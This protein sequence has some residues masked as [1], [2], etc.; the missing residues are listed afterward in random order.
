VVLRRHGPL[1]QVAQIG[2]VL[3]TGLR[4]FS[5]LLAR[6]N[7]SQVVFVERRGGTTVVRVESTEVPPHIAAALESLL[8]S[9]LE[10]LPRAA[11][12]AS[13]AN[14]SA[15][16]A[17]NASAASSAVG[18]HAP[19]RR[20]LLFRELVLAV[21]ERVRS[22]WDKA[23][24][25]HEAFS[26]SIELALTYDYDSAS[27]HDWPPTRS[28][29]EDTCSE[30]HELLSLSIDV[31][32]GIFDGW[33]TLTHRRNDLQARPVDTLAEAWPVLRREDERA[34]GAGGPPADVLELRASSAD[35]FVTQTCTAG[36]AAGFR[37]AGVEPR[38]VYDLFYSVASAANASF[39]C[40][41]HAVQTCSG[42][43]RR[44]WHAVVIVVLWFSAACV[45]FN[46]L[47]ISFLSSLLVPFFSLVVLQLCYG[48]TWTCAPMVPVCAWQD[49]SES[50]GALMPLSLEVPAELKRLDA[51]CLV[52]DTACAAAQ[53]S[54]DAC[55]APRRYPHPRC[56]KSC[57]E[58]PFSFT[59]WQHVVAWAVAEAGP[60]AVDWASTHAPRI[61]LFEHKAF[62]KN[63]QKHVN[64]LRRTSEDSVGAHRVCALLSSYM[65]LPY[66]FIVL[67][68]LAFVASLAQ[69]L[70]T[71]LLPVFLLVCTL[72]NAVADE[73]EGEAMSEVI[74]LSARH[75]EYTCGVCNV[76]L[77]PRSYAAL[78]GNSDTITCCP[79]CRRILFLDL[80]AKAE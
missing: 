21:E 63:I 47:G 31:A 80:A 45:I 17:A 40:P 75:R 14:A 51:H 18:A 13:A 77:P 19:G 58:A 29:G 9:V 28:A 71:Q 66:I 20:L 2:T 24:G 46:A 36:A 23:D 67:L 57:R 11:V 52:T 41:Y 6:R 74:E 60:W 53:S 61:P 22:G 37:A 8:E 12:N 48:Y 65:L 70:A 39:S 76:E 62:L 30:A 7:A 72:F 26:Q 25:L 64:T 78:M 43:R 27:T 38:V 1:L 3:H 79:S 16:R 69:A 15:A 56:L 34:D 32:Q 10:L 33:L 59:S 49:F 4:E 50:V 68:V 55:L 44:L 73:H 35:D 42:W 5:S 54:V